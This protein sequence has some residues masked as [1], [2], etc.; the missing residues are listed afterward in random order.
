MKYGKFRATAKDLTLKTKAAAAAAIKDSVTFERVYA[1][2]IV[3]LYGMLFMAAP[4]EAQATLRSASESAFNTI[5]GVV[6]AVGGVA[7]LT[8]LVN[9]KMGNIFGAQDPK[10]TVIHALMGTGGAFG[11]VGIIQAIK[12]ATSAGSSISGV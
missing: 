4:A 9:W 2:G 12:A 7:T 11:V 6:G 10:K 1:A 3:G 8:A 5:Y